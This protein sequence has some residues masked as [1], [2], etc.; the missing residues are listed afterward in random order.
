MGLLNLLAWKQDLLALDGSWKILL[1]LNDQGQPIDDD[2]KIFVPWLGTFCHNGLLCP[3]VPAGWPKVDEKFKDDCWKEIKQR[4]L[5]DEDIVKPLD[6]KGWAMHI[7]GVLRRNRRTKLKKIHVRGWTKEQVLARRT[8]RRVMAEQ[9]EEMVNYW[10]DEKTVTLSNKNKVSRGKQKEIAIS[11][12]ESFAQISHDMA[13]DKG[14]PVERANVYLKVYRRRDGTGVTPHAQGNITRMEELL[15]RE[16][17]R[18]QGETGSGI[19]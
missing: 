3:L 9:W 2:G 8:P 4:Y 11:G 6:Q 13:K 19:L 1:P 17:V 16:G 7:L 5:I 15:S 14:A 10:F 18:L 12:A